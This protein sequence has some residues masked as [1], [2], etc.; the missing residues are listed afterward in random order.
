MYSCKQVDAKYFYL[1]R[2]KGNGGWSCCLCKHHLFFGSHACAFLRNTSELARLPI[3]RCVFSLSFFL[4]FACSFL[5]HKHK[6]LIKI[7]VEDK[8]W[9]KKKPAYAEKKSQKDC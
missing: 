6:E 9:N 8:F 7:Q 3:Q 5:F 4:F 2:G 1:G